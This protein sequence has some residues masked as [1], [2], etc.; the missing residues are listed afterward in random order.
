MS[1]GARLTVVYLLYHA[2]RTVAELVA[3]LARQRPPAG[4]DPAT[5]IEAI[6]IDDASADDTLPRLDAALATAKLP[7]LVRVIA[8]ET[9]RGL[10]GSLN[11]AL[12]DVE[13]EYVLTCHL[14][15]RF[16]AD[17][18][19]ARVIDLLDRNPDVAVVSGQPVADMEG[20]LSHVEKIYLTANL[21]DI[22]ADSTAEL[23]PVGFAEGRCD[24]FRL[25]VLRQVGYYDTTSR[26]AGEDQVVAA[27][28]R[29]AGYRICQAPALRY[30]LS[31]S[32]AQD[33]LG[34]LVRHAHLFGRTHP[35]IVLGTRGTLAGVAGPA[36]GRNLTLRTTL[37]VLQLC[38]AS[39]SLGVAAAT[40]TRRSRRPAAA[41]LVVTG[42]LKALLFL[43]Y[44]RS[45]RFEPRDVAALALLQP[46]LDTAYAAGVIRGVW[47]LLRRRGSTIT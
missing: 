44:V 26:R 8:S 34:K 6:F 7:F 45:L 12:A 23:D 22:F 5:W 32:S 37:R 30:Y 42:A 10:S 39:A 29:A 16:A 27:K 15:C 46:A 14:D 33:S 47:H 18:Y 31:V 1:D 35:Y 36:A 4:A 11:R 19:V 38:G 17:D 41:A 13:T 25:S 24:G 20:G 9:N 40:A 28:I 2:Q 43:R 3:A 21:L